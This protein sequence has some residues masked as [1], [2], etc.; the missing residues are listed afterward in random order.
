MG[1]ATAVV[2]CDDKVED[3]VRIY[4]KKERQMMIITIR[5]DLTV[6]IILTLCGYTTHIVR[7]IVTTISNQDEIS[8][9]IIL[10][11]GNIVHD[12]FCI[13]SIS[14]YPIL[15]KLSKIPNRGKT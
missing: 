6:H 2:L 12:N 10:I 7:S 11:I 8:T 13:L 9:F 3:K 15:Y 5:E 14:M 1:V 4:Q